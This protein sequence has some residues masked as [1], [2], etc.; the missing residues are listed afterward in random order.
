[1]G[2]VSVSSRIGSLHSE[3]VINRYRDAGADFLVMMFLTSGV[4]LF[5]KSQNVRRF[6][7]GRNPNNNSAK[8]QP[9]FVSSTLKEWEAKGFI[10]RVPVSEVKCLLPLSVAD[11][12]SHSKDK[13]KY[14]LGMLPFSVIIKIAFATKA[15]KRLFFLF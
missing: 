6:P 15:I 5:L 14:R 8:A 1:M 12:W 2:D 10:K 3:E 11:R 9:E 7:R 13:L 4:P